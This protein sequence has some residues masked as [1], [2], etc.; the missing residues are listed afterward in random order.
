MSTP[1]VFEQIQ[2]RVVK[3]INNGLALGYCGCALWRGKASVM[4]ARIMRVGD[5]DAAGGRYTGSE[6]GHKNVP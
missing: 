1:L 5:L 2:P 6:P 4:Y 3:M